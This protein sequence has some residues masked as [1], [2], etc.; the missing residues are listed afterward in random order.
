MVH[1]ELHL[2]AVFG[3]LALVHGEAGVV[4]EHVE[5]VEA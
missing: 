5:P 4:H 3:E 1:L 2:V